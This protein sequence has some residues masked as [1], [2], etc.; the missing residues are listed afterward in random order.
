MECE[1]CGKTLSSKQL[2]TIHVL[3]KHRKNVETY[4]SSLFQST[5]SVLTSALASALP[6]TRESQFKT[7]TNFGVSPIFLNADLRQKPTTGCYKFKK[8]KGN[9]KYKL[10][11]AMNP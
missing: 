4:R 11:V 2:L 1:E 3:K 9:S 8:S 6:S 10:Q 5:G 7:K